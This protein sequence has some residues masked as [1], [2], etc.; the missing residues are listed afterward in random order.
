MNKKTYS[1][2]CEQHL[3]REMRMYVRVANPAASTI[4]IQTTACYLPHQSSSILVNG[5]LYTRAKIIQRPCYI[6][7]QLSRFSAQPVL[8]PERDPGQIGPGLPGD[9]V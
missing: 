1:V 7:I 6:P 9:D 5:F 3:L 8:W 4:T 2:V